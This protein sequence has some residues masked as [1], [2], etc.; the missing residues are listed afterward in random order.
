MPRT[1]AGKLS[2]RK[3]ATKDAN[4]GK[5]G[6]F[7]TEVH[8]TIKKAK[9]ETAAFFIEEIKRLKLAHSI[10]IRLAV[11]EAE[12]RGFISSFSFLVLLVGIVI[13]AALMG[14]YRSV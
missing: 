12:K 7:T 10:D 6:Q 4:G 8:E 1:K 5:L 11:R 9:E 13:G 2:P 14:I 3:V